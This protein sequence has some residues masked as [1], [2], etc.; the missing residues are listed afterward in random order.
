MVLKTTDKILIIDNDTAVRQFISDYLE[1]GGFEILQTDTVEKGLSI[2]RAE[3]PDLI[4]TDL[5][6]PGMTGLELLEILA[7]ESPQTPIVVVSGIEAM[8][9]VIQALKRGA[10]DYVM[11]PL[12]DMILLERSIGKALERSRLVEENR[13][14]RVAL[15]DANQALKKNLDILEQDQEAGR[16]VQMR[17]LPQQNVGFGPYAFTHSVVPSLYLSGDFVDYFKINDRHFG[18]YIADVSGHGASS[19]F[20]TVLLKSLV[21]LELTRYEIH[22][23]T[24]ILE[25]DA[26]L[27]KLATEIYTAKL[28]KYLTMVYGVIN[29]KDHTFTYSIGGHYPNPIWI[30]N[31]K[32]HFLEGKGFPVGIMK[33]TQY[34]KHSLI[35]KEDVQLVMFSDGVA[36][37]L[38]ANDLPKKEEL[39]LSLVVAS[40]GKVEYLLKELDLIG[41]KELPDDVTT[42]IIKRK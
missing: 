17:L 29:W 8:D 7:K 24:T 35:F 26:L 40:Q 20:V 28:G 15:E 23:E 16:S 10:W 37:I 27:S 25:P 30:E 13:Q 19:A 36:E 42:L 31:G 18:F 11:K 9:D 2:F 21:E 38:K 1:D 34:E 3:K 39:L 5:K 41:K 4:L 22:G 12:K 32:A 33:Q 6:M 14:Y